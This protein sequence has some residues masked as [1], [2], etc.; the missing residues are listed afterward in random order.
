[1]GR[2]AGLDLY[3]TASQA[4]HALVSSLGATPIDYRNEDFVTRIH[5]LTGD[6]VDVVFDSLGGDNLERSYRSLRLDGR[7]VAYGYTGAT[8][9]DSVQ[10]SRAMVEA[11]QGRQEGRTVLAYGIS[12]MK[13]NQPVWF[14]EDLQ[15]LFDLLAQRHIQPVIAARLSLAEVARAHELLEQGAVSGKIVLYSKG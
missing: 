11:L 14:K 3:G 4:K 6:G 10:A 5:S 13:Q 2:L 9:P 15:Q 7:L 8:G 12:A 1:L